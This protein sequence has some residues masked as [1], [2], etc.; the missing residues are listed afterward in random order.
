MA[1]KSLTFKSP[2]TMNLLTV[3]LI[4]LCIIS[5]GVRYNVGSAFVWV[6]HT[7]QGDGNP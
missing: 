6:G 7:L 3:L 4:V 1:R 5:P 2:N